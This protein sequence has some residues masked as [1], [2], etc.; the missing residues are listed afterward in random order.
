MTKPDLLTVLQR[1]SRYSGA[2]DMLEAIRKAKGLTLEEVGKAMHP[3]VSAAR[4]RDLKFTISMELEYRKGDDPRIKR[5][6]DALGLSDVQQSHFIKECHRRRLLFRHTNVKGTSFLDALAANIEYWDISERKL[7]LINE[8]QGTAHREY[9]E[10]G[11]ITAIAQLIRD[12]QFDE[13]QFYDIAAA[14]IHE[15]KNPG[16]FTRMMNRRNDR[17][18]FR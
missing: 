14:V 12:P 13:E 6:L 2:D 7:A 8:Y 15:Q 5:Y 4:A 1:L 9:Y 16:R 18:F 3:P 17:E 11:C 10:K